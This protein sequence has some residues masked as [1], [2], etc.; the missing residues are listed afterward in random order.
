MQGSQ[1]N[2]LIGVLIWLMI[3][4]MMLKV[5]GVLVEGSVMISA[6]IFCNWTRG[7]FDPRRTL[8]RL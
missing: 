6:C 1:V 5:V 3:Y 8:N 2:V 4:P 7:R